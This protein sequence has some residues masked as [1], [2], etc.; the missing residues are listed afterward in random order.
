M[1]LVF[2]S[3]KVA[4]DNKDVIKEALSLS[5]AGSIYGIGI[6]VLLEMGSPMLLLIG[7]TW[8]LFCCSNIGV[9]EVTTEGSVG[10]GVGIGLGA[11]AGVGVEGVL[12]LISLLLLSI[13][14]H[15]PKAR[16]DVGVLLVLPLIPWLCVGVL[17][18]LSI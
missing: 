16:D 7:I 15:L 5:A 2:L 12:L 11:G 18:V 10:V 8:I 6:V 13:L 9:V 3:C 4:L 14:N 1:L 17:G